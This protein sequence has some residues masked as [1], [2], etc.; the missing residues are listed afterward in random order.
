M[1]RLCAT[2]IR[3]FQQLSIFNYAYRWKA[4]NLQALKESIVLEYMISE[5][6]Q[7]WTSYDSFRAFLQSKIDQYEY[8]LIKW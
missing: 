7:R 8:N 6:S 4:I 1:G 3:N 2:F 5:T